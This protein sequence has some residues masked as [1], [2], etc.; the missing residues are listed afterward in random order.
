MTARAM[1]IILMATAG[2]QEENVIQKDASPP[3][4]MEAEAA[5]KEE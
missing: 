4:N 1:E 2:N 5:G 3:D